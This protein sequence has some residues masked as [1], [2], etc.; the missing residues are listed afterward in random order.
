MLPGGHPPQH[1]AHILMLWFPSGGCILDYH[2]GCWCVVDGGWWGLLVDGGIAQGLGLGL[3]YSVGAGAGAVV[4]YSVGAGFGAGVL[5][6][7]G[8]GFGAG[9]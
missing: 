5:Y 4:L 7:V 8:A 1:L 9:V 2:R 6:S 3:G